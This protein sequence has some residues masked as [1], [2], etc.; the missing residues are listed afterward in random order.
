[1]CVYCTRPY[2][3]YTYTN[4]EKAIPQLANKKSLKSYDKII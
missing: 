1:M 4:R 2:A 3:N